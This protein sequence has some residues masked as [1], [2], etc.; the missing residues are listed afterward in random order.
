[1][2]CYFFSYWCQITMASYTIEQHVQMIT[3]YYQNEFVSANVA[4]ITSILRHTRW[5]FK[6]DFPT[7]G[8][9]IREDWFGKQPTPLRQRNANRPR[10]SL[11]SVRVCRRLRGSR[12]LAVRKNSAFR[13]L[14]LGE[15]CVRTWAYTHTRSNAVCSLT[16]LQNVWKRTPNLVEKSSVRNIA[17]L[18]SSPRR[19]RGRGV[20]LQ[21]K[22]T[23]I[24]EKTHN[25]CR[26]R[27]IVLALI[28]FNKPA[29]NTVHCYLNKSCTQHLIATAPTHLYRRCALLDEWF[30]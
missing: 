19:K 14:Q 9:Q 29:I 17:T 24:N 23:C 20:D 4:R 10:T 7:F 22:T 18:F 12:F 13:R 26:S 3:C 1:M 27:K 6:V 28:R 15:F 21:N 25:H 8:V 5:P 2:R 30:C 16:R 11:L